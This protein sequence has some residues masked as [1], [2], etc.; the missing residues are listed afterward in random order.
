M[1]DLSDQCQ[2][3]GL[4]MTVLA[5]DP[6]GLGGIAIRSRAGPVRER[7]LDLVRRLPGPSQRIS[8]TVPDDALFGGLDVA[9]TLSGGT[10]VY[11]R[12]LIETA[13]SLVLAM[14]ERTTPR[15]AARIAMRLDEGQ[16]PCL[17]A[18]DEGAEPEEALPAS[19]SERL[20]FAVD[21]SDVAWGNLPVW[22]DESARIEAARACLPNVRFGNDA[23]RT[24]GTLC[25]SL[26]IDTARA[27]IFAKRAAV[28]LA[29]LDG[30]D[31]VGSEDIE[32]PPP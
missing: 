24:L 9:A 15:L 8:P 14:A 27:P 7:C 22:R 19:L 5:V 18:L 26:G 10:P 31:T 32:P 4:A 13:R 2:R 3:L 16:G 11:R 17:V 1:A 12:G 30:R 29:A 20:A 23:Y 25:L 28:V 6:G 21:L